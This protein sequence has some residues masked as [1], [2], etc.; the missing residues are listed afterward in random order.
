MPSHFYKVCLIELDR[1][2]YVTNKKRT[3]LLIMK[4]N[5]ETNDS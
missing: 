5:K 1:I 2:M 4:G 3:K